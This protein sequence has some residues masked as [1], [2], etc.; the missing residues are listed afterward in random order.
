MLIVACVLVHEDQFSTAVHVP[1][2]FR[3]VVIAERLALANGNHTAGGHALGNQIVLHGVSA[4]L[5]ELQVVSVGADAVGPAEEL[6]LHVRVFHNDS[7]GFIKDALSFGGQV[8]LVEGEVDAT[9]DD[10][11]FN[12]GHAFLAEH[13]ANELYPEMDRLFKES[14]CPN[15]HIRTVEGDFSLETFL[16][17]LRTIHPAH[18]HLAP[19]MIVAGDHASNDMAGEDEDSWKSI[20]EKEGF[21]ISCTLQGLGELPSIRDIFLRHVRAGSAQLTR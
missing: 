17:E 10:D 13:I 8:V 1:A 20:L 15:I 4:A 21:Q 12:D 9:E 18:V 5:G 16:E 2:F 19:F 7:G 6:H 3:I 14:G 11:V